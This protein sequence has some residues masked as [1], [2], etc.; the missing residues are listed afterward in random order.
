MTTREFWEVS[1]RG[2]NFTYISQEQKDQ[3]GRFF[4]WFKKG[5]GEDVELN[6]KGKSAVKRRVQDL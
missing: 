6:A 5:A 1:E 4:S 3:L 2:V